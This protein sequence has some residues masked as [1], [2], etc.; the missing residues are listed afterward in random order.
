[1]PIPTQPATA[2]FPIHLRSHRGKRSNGILR[3]QRASAAPERS[4]SYG[5]IAPQRTVVLHRGATTRPPRVA[6]SNGV[7]GPVEC[8]GAPVASRNARIYGDNG[9]THAVV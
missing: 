7:Y 4:R 5:H 9:L 3:T 6:R 1:M 2:P 8:A